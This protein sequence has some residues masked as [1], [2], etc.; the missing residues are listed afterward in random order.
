M[1]ILR[2]FQPG[3]PSYKNLH[4]NQL[5]FLVGWELFVKQRA[6]YNFKA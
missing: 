2:F 3:H 5:P 6:S 1:P 4:K